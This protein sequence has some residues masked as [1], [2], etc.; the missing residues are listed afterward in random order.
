MKDKTFSGQIYNLLYELSAAALQPAMGDAK[1]QA[2]VW[3]PKARIIINIFGQRTL[4]L[5]L[6][7]H[8]YTTLLAVAEREFALPM[9]LL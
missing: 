9:R 2:A 1:V 6:I 3:Q 5:S 7:T 4:Y 8:Y